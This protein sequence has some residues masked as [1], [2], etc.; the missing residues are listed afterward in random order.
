MEAEQKV[1]KQVTPGSSEKTENKRV[2]CRLCLKRRVYQRNLPRHV[3]EFHPKFYE[4]KTPAEDYAARED[5]EFADDP[6]F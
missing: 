4:E 3:K 2:Q 6:E 5:Q 1:N